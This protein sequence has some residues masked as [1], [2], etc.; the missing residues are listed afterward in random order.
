MS[1]YTS[2]FQKPAVRTLLG[3][4]LGLL[5]VAVLAPWLSPYDPNAVVLDER[6]LPASPEHWL[7]T[8]H[9]GRDV[10]TRLIYGARIS[11]GAL[12]CIVS[13]IV[14]I[15]TVLGCT[16]ALVGGRVQSC[17][18]RLCDVFMTFP[19]FIL[20]LFLIAILGSGLTNVIIA[21]VLTHW[22]WYTRMVCAMVLNLKNNEY[23]LASRVAGSPRWRMLV[24]HILPTV[25]VQLAVLASLDIGHMLLHVSALSFIGLGVTPPTPEWGIM[26]GD[27]RPYIRTQPQLMLY[28]GSMIFCTVM[29]FNALGDALRDALDPHISPSPA[30]NWAPSLAESNLRDT[31]DP[32]LPTASTVR[33]TPNLRGEL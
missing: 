19:T 6:F 14:V 17:I 18:M 32:G 4:V 2:P 1:C 26:L 10:L 9:L 21:I 30:P 20:A 29:L 23:V 15:G 11:V 7:G 3:L 12:A 33:E 31:P 22:A 5:S 8:D 24:E 27:A 25:L 13:L 28:A 16:A